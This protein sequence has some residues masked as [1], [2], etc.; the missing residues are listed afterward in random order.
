SPSRSSSGTT[1]RSSS[2]R[3][4]TSTASPRSR[5]RA[6]CSTMSAR[7]PLRSRSKRSPPVTP[8]SSRSYRT[9][10]RRRRTPQGPRGAAYGP[11]GSDGSSFFRVSCS[12]DRGP[13]PRTRSVSSGSASRRPRGEVR[14]PRRR[15][16][17]DPCGGAPPRARERAARRVDH[18]ADHLAAQV[19]PRTARL[20]RGRGAR[21][22]GRRT[23]GAGQ[24]SA[25]GSVPARPFGGRRT[26]R[27]RGHRLPSPGPMGSAARGVRRGGGGDGPRVSPR[28]H[29]GGR[30]R[31][32]DPAPG[33]RG[34]GCV[35]RGDHDRPRLARGG[36]RAP[37]RVP[38]ALGRVLGCV[39][40]DGAGDLGVRA[41]AARRP[42]GGGAT[43]RPA[44]PRR[45][46]RPVPRRRR[47]APQTARLPV[48][49]APDRR[50]GRG[51][52]RDR[53]RR[54][55]RA[56]HLSA[57]LGPAAPH[58]VPDRVPHGRNLPG[59]GRYGGAHRRGAARAAGGH[60]DGAAGC[61]TVRLS[62]P[63]MDRELIVAVSDLTCR[64]PGAPRDALRAVSLEVR[65]SEF[66]ALLGPNGSGKTTLVRAALGLV[67][68]VQG[69][70][71]ILGRPA[72][73]WSRRALAQEPKLL[74]LDE[75]T[76]SLDLRHEMELF[77]RVRTLVDGFGLAALMITHHVNLAARFADQILI[78]AEGRAVARGAP[79]AVLTRETVERVF[80]WPV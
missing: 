24:E 40:D 55:D 37:Q 71:E 18:V 48:R 2:G 57:G 44:R 28:A 80:S 69:R 3:G 54:I 75:P 50:R 56:A 68:P 63:P 65:A 19:A 43:P 62:A 12:G 49:L 58:P 26:R 4:A 31:P 9:A 27:G 61:A 1:H 23:P 66:H 5:G 25:R 7:P 78:L 60:R 32:P 22:L 52:G 6:M 16:A 29:R 38:L 17:R 76:V 74:V 73:D 46:A 35:R 15:R 70:A 72:G 11:C 36:Y 77:E 10:R 79:A 64:Y 39:V 59:R 67:R 53:L 14:S 41:A 21:R 20:S 45:G 47:A 51:G 34:R 8:I 42:R 13:A 33:R 30:A